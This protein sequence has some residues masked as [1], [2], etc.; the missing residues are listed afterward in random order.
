MAGDEGEWFEDVAGRVVLGFG[1]EMERDCSGATGIGRLPPMLVQFQELQRNG[2]GP[3]K[4]RAASPEI[5]SRTPCGWR[6]SVEK[7]RKSWVFMKRARKRADGRESMAATPDRDWRLGGPG[8]GARALLRH[9]PFPPV[10]ANP[11]SGCLSK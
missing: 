8:H 5:G 6:C 7:T 2:G 4:Q 11:P 1:E 9:R 3:V 10:W